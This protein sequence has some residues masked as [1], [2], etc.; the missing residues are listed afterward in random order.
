[1]DLFDLLKKIRKRP[2]MYL[3][4]ISISRL[5]T[6][7]AGY[8]F[9]RRQAGIPQTPQE[10]IFETF[11][12][13]VEHQLCDFSYRHWDHMIL[14]ISETE[15]E[16]IEHFFELF[17]GFVEHQEVKKDAAKLILKTEKQ[18]VEQQAIRV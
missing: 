11:Q 7:L 3:G 10:K 9:A 5:Q 15:E 16:A 14:D 13:W 18:A 12:L 6:F 17:D 8:N 4:E 2:A 1:M